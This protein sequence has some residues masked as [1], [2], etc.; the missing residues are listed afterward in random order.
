[1]PIAFKSSGVAFSIWDTS[2][3]PS[4]CWSNISWLFAASCKRFSSTFWGVG[5]DCTWDKGKGIV[6]RGDST[7]SIIV[8]FGSG[9]SKIIVLANCFSVI[10]INLFPF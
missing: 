1:M 10:P 4:A 8:G 6:G 7:S 2:I 9:N 3:F 5:V